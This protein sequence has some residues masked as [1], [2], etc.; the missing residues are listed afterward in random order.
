M[1]MNLDY[2]IRRAISILIHRATRK[3]SNNYFT[4]LSVGDLVAGQNGAGIQSG[5]FARRSRKLS[6]EDVQDAKE[7]WLERPYAYEFYHQMRSCWREDCHLIISGEISKKGHSVFESLDAGKPIPDFLIHRPGSMVNNCAVIEVK[8]QNAYRKGI[9][10]DVEKLL[11]FKYRI[12]YRQ[13]IYLFFG[14]ELPKKKSKFQEYIR[15]GVG[16]W[17]SEPANKDLVKNSC[18]EQFEKESA[19]VELWW[20]ELPDKPAEYERMCIPFLE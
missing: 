4:T 6:S 14:E 15:E 12:G 10:R 17:W 5:R 8:S 1:D 19:V 11:T 7:R 16:C 18:F 3:I 20:H 2:S 13:M 9:Y